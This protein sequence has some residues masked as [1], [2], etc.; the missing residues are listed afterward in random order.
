MGKDFNRT[1][2]TQPLKARL[3]LGDF[4]VT[5]DAIDR[6]PP[7]PDNEGAA[8]ALREFCLEMGVQDHWHHAF[9]KVREFI[10]R[11]IANGKPI[12][13]QLDCIYVAKDKMQCT[14]DWSIDPSMVPTDHWLVT[15]KY[16]PKKA[17]FISKG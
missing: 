3:V 10:Y 6:F 17:P 14:F 7:K 4:N 11:G 5:E 2:K 13:S 8:R 12:K 16:T 15:V 1:D 9:P